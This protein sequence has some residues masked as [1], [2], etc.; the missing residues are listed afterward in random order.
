MGRLNDLRDRVYKT[1]V[2]HGFTDA[3]IGED[4][5]LMVSEVAE[6]LEDFRAS[7]GPEVVWYERKVELPPSV[8]DRVVTFLSALKLVA[9][10]SMRTATVITSEPFYTTDV[11]CGVCNGRGSHVDHAASIAD[12]CRTCRGTGKRIVLNKPCGIRSEM[13]DV[14]IRVLHFCG[15]HSIDIDAAVDEKTAYNDARPYKH[16]GK[17]L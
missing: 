10:P 11:S 2:D 7:R 13:A 3:S 5:M 16:G 17:T 1:A 9:P 14:I 8:T 4:F 15:K 12:Q 6:A